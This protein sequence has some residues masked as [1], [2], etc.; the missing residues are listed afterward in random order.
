MVPLAGTAHFSSF[1]QQQKVLFPMP[2]GSDNWASDKDL[3]EIQRKAKLSNSSSPPPPSKRNQ[4][5]QCCHTLH[6]FAKC[7][8]SCEYFWAVCNL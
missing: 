5:D 1:R 3:T 4:T 6:N 7:E 2:G 8:I